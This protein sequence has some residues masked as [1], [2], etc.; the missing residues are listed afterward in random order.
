MKIFS[1]LFSEPFIETLK[2]LVC[3]RREGV[4]SLGVVTVA[5][6][7]SGAHHVQF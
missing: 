4:N 6:W 5:G 1:V 7:L 2:V 3:M